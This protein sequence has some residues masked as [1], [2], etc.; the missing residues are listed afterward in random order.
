MHWRFEDGI[1]WLDPSIIGASSRVFTAERR[2]VGESNGDNLML[3]GVC[4]FASDCEG[5]YSISLNSGN[6]CLGISDESP[7]PYC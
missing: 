2:F 4:W 6:S 3:V 1:I 5:E 7:C